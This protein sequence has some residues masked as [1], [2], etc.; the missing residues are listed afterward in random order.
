[1]IFARK[2]GRAKWDPQEYLGDGEISADAVTADL[3]TMN[4]AVSFWRFESENDI[5]NAILA[6]ASIM[7]SAETFDVAWVNDSISAPEFFIEATPGKTPVESLSDKHADIGRLDIVRLG[8][9]AALIHG[10]IQAGHCKRLYKKDVVALLASAVRKGTLRLDRIKEKVRPQI[11][12]YLASH[13][14]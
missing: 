4:N 1:M 13:P 3:R 11:E 5:D 2:I 12:Q 14:D 10:A 7:D 9:L 6:L 8:K